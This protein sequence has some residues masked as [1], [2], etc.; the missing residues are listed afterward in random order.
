LQR[1]AL[2]GG[3]GGVSGAD[4][5]LLTRLR[6]NLPAMR[7][8][9]KRCMGHW[10]YEDGVYRFYHHSFKVYRLQD[11][12]LEIVGVLRRLAPGRELDQDFIRIV[13]DGTGRSF[14]ASDNL[15]WARRTRPIL[16]AFF[17][18]LYFLDVAVRYGSSLRR[19]PRVLPSGWAS[20]LTLY[21]LR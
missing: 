8:L 5:K 3:L 20:L 16:E 6:R 18:A 14:R 17:H 2:S 7:E 11:A 19:P 13:R 21:G 10:I 1:R 9:R 12:T 15:R 4:A